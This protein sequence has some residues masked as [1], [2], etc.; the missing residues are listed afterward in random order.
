MPAWRFSVTLAINLV[1]AMPSGVLRYSLERSDNF[2]LVSGD[3]TWPVLAHDIEQN[4]PRP[5]CRFL[6]W[7]HSFSLY[8]PGMVDIYVGSLPLFATFYH[9]LL[10]PLPIPLSVHGQG[11]GQTH[12]SIM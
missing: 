12:W 8:T 10:L 6:H 11:N 3:F 7:G 9:F 5:L 1:V 2:L 4:N